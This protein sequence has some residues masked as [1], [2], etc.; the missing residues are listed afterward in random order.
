MR[1]SI[2]L[3]LLLAAVVLSGCLPKTQ[4]NTPAATLAATG[5]FK[6]APTVGLNVPTAAAVFPDS[7]CTV[8]T[9]KPTPGPTAVPPYPAISAADWAKGPTDAKVTIVE[10]SDFQ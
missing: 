2:I 1:K 4:A 7:G 8:V 10:Y 9:Q 5:T 6:P 3:F